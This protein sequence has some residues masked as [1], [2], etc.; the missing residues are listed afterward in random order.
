MLPW[1]G[2]V[3]GTT[4]WKRTLS[5]SAAIA[6]TRSSRFFP[7]IVSLA[8]TRTRFATLRLSLAF[9]RRCARRLLRPRLRRRLEDAVHRVRHAVLVRAADHGRHRVEGED[10]RRRGHLPLQRERPPG[11]GRSARAAAPGG[12][13]VV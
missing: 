3:C 12:G 5:S 13:T 6:F 11:V 4:T 7:P 10:R 9:G 8:R 2:R 1:R